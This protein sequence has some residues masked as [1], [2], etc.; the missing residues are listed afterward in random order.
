MYIF[1][2]NMNF[3]FILMFLVLPQVPNSNLTLECIASWH[4]LSC[5][6]RYV[7]S[8]AFVCLFVSFSPFGEVTSFFQKTCFCFFSCESII[9][10]HIPFPCHNTSSLTQRNAITCFPSHSPSA[11]ACN[12]ISHFH[13]HPSHFSFPSARHDYTKCLTCNCI[14]KVRF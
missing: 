10:F 4:F 1:S 12:S 7:F 2:L 14:Q 9:T 11:C 3:S 8:F 13:F 5:F 6:Q